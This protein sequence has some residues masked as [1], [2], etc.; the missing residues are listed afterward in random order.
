MALE[1]DPNNARIH[2]NLGF[3]LWGKGKIEEAVNEYEKS[4]KLDPSYDIAYNNLG[5]IYLDDLGYIQEAIDNLRKAI[6]S[7][8]QYALA[9][10]NLGRAMAVKGDKIEAARLF[11][12]AMDLNNHTNEMD[13]REIKVKIQ[14]LFE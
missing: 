13:Q 7:N 11:Q 6:E 12:V 5:V 2:C 1:V 14:E 8:T 4:I 3:L 9:N 10:Y